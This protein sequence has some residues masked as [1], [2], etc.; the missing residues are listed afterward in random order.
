MQPAIS[1][2][3]HTL[4]GRNFDKFVEKLSGDQYKELIQTE[5]EF[6]AK[7]NGHPFTPQRSIHDVRPKKIGGELG[8]MIEADELECT[9]P[10]REAQEYAERVANAAATNTVRMYN[11]LRKHLD[12][13][14]GLDKELCEFVD[15]PKNIPIMPIPPAGFA[16]AAAQAM[17]IAARAFGAKHHREGRF[18]DNEINAM[19]SV[20]KSG[21]GLPGKMFDPRTELAWEAVYRI[22]VAANLVRADRTKQEVE[23]EPAAKPKP[24]VNLE[25]APLTPAEQKRH[26]YN[27]GVVAWK[28]KWY[29][30][31]DVDA[32]GSEEY[33]HLV[34]ETGYDGG[35]VAKNMSQVLTNV[36]M[37]GE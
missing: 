6:E 29:T 14:I 35:V 10:E 22:C 23:P 11:K 4:E 3:W 34:V 17:D 16:G 26:Y 7:V 37:G 28:G 9:R 15:L 13:A 27:K 19:Y 25:P 18:S 36:L 2:V 8:A 12:M 33:K 5:P 24:K 20:L 32:M 21:C 31:S 1:N 30:Q